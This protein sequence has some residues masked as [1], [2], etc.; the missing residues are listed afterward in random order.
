MKLGEVLSVNDSMLT[1]ACITEWITAGCASESRPYL[2]RG[3]AK[4]ANAYAYPITE[5]AF[6]T[7]HSLP[8]L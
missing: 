7:E 3:R 8:F 1:G 6:T 4:C 5:R 2:V